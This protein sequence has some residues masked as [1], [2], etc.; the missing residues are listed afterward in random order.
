MGANMTNFQMLRTLKDFIPKNKGILDGDEVEKIESALC[1]K[2][3]DNI[4]D[5]RNLRDFVVCFYGRKADEYEHN[6]DID[7]EMTI[8]DIISGITAVIDSRIFA[9]GGEV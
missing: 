6:Y 3:R 2:E 1:I 8:R 9:L 7:G 5:L 4:L